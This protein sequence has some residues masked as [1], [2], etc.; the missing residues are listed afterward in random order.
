V[1]LPNGNTVLLIT[2]A[3]LQRKKVTATNVSNWTPLAAGVNLT[4]PF[5][6]NKPNFLSYVWSGSEP[7]GTYT[8][9]LTVAVPGSFADGTVDPGDIIH[10]DT[11]TITFAP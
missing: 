8:F 3:A 2:N 5:T 11:A 4:S 1:V 9:F 7:A 6:A 10:S